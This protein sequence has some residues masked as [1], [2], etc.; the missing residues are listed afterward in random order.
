MCVAAAP[1][2][3]GMGLDVMI[4]QLGNVPEKVKRNLL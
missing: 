2:R 1:I 3:L 4:L